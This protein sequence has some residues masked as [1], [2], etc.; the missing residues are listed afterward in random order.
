[1]KK[2]A[3]IFLAIVL[4]TL[5][6]AQ[7]LQPIGPG[8]PEVSSA[9]VYFQNIS[10]GSS[11]VMATLNCSQTTKVTFIFSYNGVKG[12]FSFQIAGKSFTVTRT[13]TQ[14]PDEYVTL[15]L[16]AGSHSV[17]I[18]KSYGITGGCPIISIY[19]G[20]GGGSNGQPYL[21]VCSGY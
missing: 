20:G 17:Y 5:L 14:K 15:T 12:T 3:F 4:P 10:T 2:L 8:N 1:M 21:N 16:P 19:G 6:A 18:D 13:D 11:S 7:S 9:P